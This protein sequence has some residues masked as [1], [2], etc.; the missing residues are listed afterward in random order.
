[1]KVPSDKAAK[2]RI[3]TSIPTDL[4]KGSSG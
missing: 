4:S 2:E 3:P 1:M